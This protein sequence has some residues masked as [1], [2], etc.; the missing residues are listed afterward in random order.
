MF[1]ILK[2]EFNLKG[3]LARGSR[4]HPPLNREMV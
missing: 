1:I 4:H 2:Y 3:P